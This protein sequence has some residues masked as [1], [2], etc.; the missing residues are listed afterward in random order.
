M[1]TSIAWLWS[2]RGLPEEK[3]AYSAISRV[4]QVKPLKMA[5]QTVRE[6]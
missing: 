4:S 5:A 6:T 3:M 2:T 1:G